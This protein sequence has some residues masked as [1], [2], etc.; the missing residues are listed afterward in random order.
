[1]RGKGWRTRPNSMSGYAGV[2]DA[3]SLVEAVHVARKI[4]PRVLVERN[5]VARAAR[6]TYLRRLM[7]LPARPPIPGRD[8]GGDA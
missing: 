6:E 2:R 4:D 7:G 1:M 8:D 5:Q 3:T